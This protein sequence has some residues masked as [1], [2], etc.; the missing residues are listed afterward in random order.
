MSLAR[1]PVLIAGVG[2]TGMVLLVTAGFVFGPHCSV[3][4]AKQFAVEDDLEQLQIQLNNYNR[5]NGSFPTTQQGLDALVSH[6]QPSPIPQQRRQGLRAIP[7]DPW[8][9]RYLYRYPGAK[10][11]QYDLFSL[12]PDGIESNDDIYRKP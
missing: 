8:H 3:E 7:E 9:H 6:P 4:Y 12:G 11:R 5:L 2:V 10:Q 1:K